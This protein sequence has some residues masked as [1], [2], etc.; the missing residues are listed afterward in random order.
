MKFVALFIVLTASAVVD[1]AQDKSTGSIKGKV[2]VERGSA[3][4]VAVVLHQG[5]QEV[6]R[7]ETD[8]KGEF[9]IARV[10]A[11]T[12]GLTFRKAGLAV[13]KLTRV[14][15]GEDG[16]TSYPATALADELAAILCSQ[17]L[18]LPRQATAKERKALP[19]CRA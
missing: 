5:D 12:Y 19:V 17:V 4:G 9:T 18:K 2:R 1:V 3:A 8:R 13:G 16:A 6:R 11:G 15:E 7:V 14:S 10:R